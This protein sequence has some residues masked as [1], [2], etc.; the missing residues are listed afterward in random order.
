VHTK[1]VL[2]LSGLLGKLYG[3][4]Q[5]VNLTASLTFEQSYEE[6]EGDSAS[7]A[8]FLALLSAIA[9]IPLRQ[10]IAVTGSINQHGM[11][12]PIGG[13]NEKIEGFYAVCKGRNL[14]GEQGVIL[15]AGNLR[16]LMLQDEVIEAVR[17]HRF[18][19][20]PVT[21]LDEAVALLTGVE[22]GA[23]QTDGSYPPGSFHAAVVARLAA[24]SKAL[25]PAGKVTA[26]S[27]PPPNEG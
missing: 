21:S 15:P 1:G 25:E 20:W 14:T 6:V 19:I 23:L 3:R 4:T 27:L 9:D 22:P 10:D 7:T 16:H 17:A 26:P 13:A 5:P 11:L 2:I 12:Q 18:H 8:E 24:F